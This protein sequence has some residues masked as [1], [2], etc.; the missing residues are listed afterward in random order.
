MITYSRYFN[1]RKI[2]PDTIWCGLCLG[3]PLTTAWS[4]AFLSDR[5]KNSVRRVMVHG[6][7]EYKEERM[8]N[9]AISILAVWRALIKEADLTVLRKKRLGYKDL[10]QGING[11]FDFTTTTPN[12]PLH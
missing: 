7:E 1:K 10:L 12:H 9:S 4:K 8:L 2:D 5:V 6:P 3:D 11:G